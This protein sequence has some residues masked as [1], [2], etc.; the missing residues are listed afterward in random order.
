VLLAFDRERLDVLRIA[1]RRSLAQLRGIRSDDVAAADAMRMLAAVCQSLDEVWLP[2]VRDVLASTAMTDCRRSEPGRADVS[3]AVLHAARDNHG[4]ETKVDTL[5]LGPPAPAAP[6]A[7]SIDDVL[8]DVASGRLRSLTGPVD[9]HGRAGARYT[10]LAFA[11]AEVHQIGQRELTSNAAKVLDFFAD[12]S[13]VGWREHTTIAMYF[14]DHVR[15]TSTVHTLTA[16]DAD[17]GPQTVPGLTTEATMTGYLIVESRE[18]VGEISVKIG[19]GDDTQTG[20]VASQPTATYAGIFVA[21][22]EPDFQPIPT[23]PRYVDAD[24]WTFTTSSSPMADEWGT[25]GL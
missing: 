8:G 19:P 4:W 5:A 6:P 2:R 18:T 10:S 7:R 13:P 25:W 23:G 1:M 16:Y 24:R 22:T 17:A 15:V 9:A 14:L 11:P 12:A 3:Q 21:E 20:V